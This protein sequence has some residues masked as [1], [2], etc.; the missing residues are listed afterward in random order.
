M[1]A[2]ALGQG[3]ILI[4]IYIYIYIEGDGLLGHDSWGPWAG[5]YIYIALIFDM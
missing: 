5:Q 2:M 3:N 1:G 4:Y